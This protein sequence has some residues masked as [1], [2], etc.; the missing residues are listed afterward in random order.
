MLLLT[1]KVCGKEFE[2]RRR[3]RS[4][5]C[6]QCAERLRKEGRGPIQ[7]RRRHPEPKEGVPEI[8]G[9]GVPGQ[10]TVAL[11]ADVPC[12]GDKYLLYYVRRF[13]RYPKY[14][15]V[16]PD[17]M[18]VLTD[19]DRELANQ[20]AARMGSQVWRNLVGESIEDVWQLDL[21]RAS[22]SAWAE[23]KERMRRALSNLFRSPGIGVARLTKALHRKRPQLIP[24]CDSVLCKALQVTAR[25]KVEIVIECM[26]KLRQVAQGNLSSLAGL[27]QLSE[28]S[29]MELSE[30]RILEILHWTEF[31]PF[32]PTP[33]ELDRWFL[34][35]QASQAPASTQIDS[36]L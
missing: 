10:I 28:K 21:L 9:H 17:S 12:P 19:H 25:N 18:N 22:D 11:V 20:V 26:D 2:A 5:H 6:G 36:Q 15:G 24:I 4:P 16:R 1:C 33:E 34:N 31:G 8:V 7:V 30:L 23:C 35:S 29:G 32:K 14:D 13:G 3:R 27:R